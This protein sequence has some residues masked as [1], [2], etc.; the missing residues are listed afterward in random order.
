M[1][2]LWA[3]GFAVLAAAMATGS[4]TAQ[5]Q[6]AVS[7][8]ERQFKARCASCHSVDAGQN[9]LGPHLSGLFGRPAGSVDGARYSAALKG[10]GIVWDAG[11]LD[12]YLANPRQTV[13]GTS[14]PTGLTDGDQR[15]Q[16]IEYLRHLSGGG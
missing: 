13:P 6:G 10:S 12:R 7:D 3:A 4:G 2:A 14:M 8:G 1:R 16:V 11:A 9:R 5:A 15:A